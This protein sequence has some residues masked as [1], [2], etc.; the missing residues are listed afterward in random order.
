MRKQQTLDTIWEVPDEFWAGDSAGY[1]GVGPT[2]A[3]GPQEGQCPAD[4]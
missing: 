4:L 1:L 3:E 2:E